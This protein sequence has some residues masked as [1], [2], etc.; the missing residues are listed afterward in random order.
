VEDFLKKVF[1]IIILLTVAS[2]GLTAQ[3]HNAI[4][5]TEY[6]LYEFLDIAQI[7]GLLRPLPAARPYARSLVARSLYEINNRR[8][9]LSP[10]EQ[11]VLEDFIERY[12]DD[13][14]LPF[15]IDGDFRLEHDV[16][17]TR[18]GGY[19]KGT[20]STDLGRIKESFGGS[21]VLGGYVKGDLGRF[22]SWG[23][24]LSFGAFLVDDYDT[25]YNYGPAGFEPYTYT[26]TWDGG[27][28][29]ISSLSS[30][31]Q[32]PT[33]LS[34]G[35][36]YAPEIAFS[37]FDNRLD[38]RFARMRHDWGI[39]EGSLVLDAGARP[40]FG[41]FTKINPLKM[42][43]LSALVGGLGGGGNCRDDF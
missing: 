24:D 40:C 26:K 36:T 37:F 41:F 1:L 8:S 3:T 21:A 30:F 12:A 25:S 35:Y 16:F 14:D 9:T 27:L 17:P 42:I 18:F 13:P 10:Y 29:P 23:I 32:M 43:Y 4:P 6:A 39:G 22:V 11:E 28:H 38:L 2:V 7:R 19:L 33:S 31:V 5:V 20:I 34:F 15:N